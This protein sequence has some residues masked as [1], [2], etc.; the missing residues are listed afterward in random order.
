MNRVLRQQGFRD[1]FIGQAVSGFGDWMVTVALMAVVLQLTKSSTAVGGILVLRLLPAALS[2]PLTARVAHRWDRQRTMLSM[3][4]VRAGL[5]AVL[6]L[7]NALWWVYVM[8]FLLELASMIFLPARDASIP[9]LAGGEDL[10]IANGLILASS[11]ATIPLGAGAF[12]AVVALDGGR[13]A[14]VFWID[15]AT[16]IVS[17]L[18]IRRLT[19]IGTLQPSVDDD[20]REEVHGRFRDAFHIPLVKTVMVPTATVAIGLGTLFSLGIVFVRDV[21]GAS[22]TEFGVLIALFGVGAGLGLV[23]L[24]A[25][26]NVD[27]LTKVRWGVT[28]QG[29]TIALMTATKGIALAFL[30]ASLFGA[31]TAFTLAAGMGTLQERL[32][33]RERVLAFSAFHVVIRIGL[34]LSAIGAG[35]AADAVNPVNLPVVGT[36]EPARLVLMCAGVLLIL[37]GG[38][39]G[40]RAEGREPRAH[41]RPG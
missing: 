21:L 23:A 7:I 9:D 20:G 1:L 17:F 39:V 4:L 29:G 35:I 5:V 19:G 8:A 36:I 6:P 30:G 40:G 33:D 28:V 34:S 16:F 11:Y 32:A 26:R 31:A 22:N 25:V 41:L 38:F 2:G 18:C 12:A 13:L 27:S 24:Q 37:A 15:A 3:D 10:P 14:P